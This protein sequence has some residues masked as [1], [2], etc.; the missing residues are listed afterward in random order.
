M[1]DMETLQPRTCKICHG[2]GYIYYGDSEEF[3][4][5]PCEC[6]EQKNG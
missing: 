1:P 3:D 4:V 6:K 2:T 5:E